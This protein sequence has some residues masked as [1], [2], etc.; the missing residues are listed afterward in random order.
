MGSERGT[1]NIWK[2][3]FIMIGMKT[4]P[5]PQFSWVVQCEILKNYSP[6]QVFEGHIWLPTY[7]INWSAPFGA[8]LLRT[9][10]KMAFLLLIPCGKRSKTALF[11]SILVQNLSVCSE[12]TAFFWVHSDTPLNLIYSILTQVIS[13]CCQCSLQLREREVDFPEISCY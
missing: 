8:W 10:E 6:V 13:C 11:P 1:V 2:V 12:V 4:G 5:A 9:K 7:S 3:L